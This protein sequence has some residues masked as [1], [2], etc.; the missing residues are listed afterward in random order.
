MSGKT[1]KIRVA[2]SATEARSRQM[3]CKKPPASF[4]VLINAL[5]CLVLCLPAAGCVGSSQQSASEEFTQ[6]PGRYSAASLDAAHP[7]VGLPLPFVAVEEGVAS[8]VRPNDD[9]AEQLLWLA[10]QTGRFNLV[11]HERLTELLSQQ[12]HGDV[13]REASLVQP[14]GIRGIDYL[15]LC[16]VTGLRIHGQEQPTT[17]SVANVERLL[18]ISKAAPKVTAG[19]L[20]D[21]RLVDPA[22]GTI[23]AEQETRFN[24]SASPDAMGLH[25]DSP[26]DAF[27]ELH[28]SDQQFSQVLRIILDDSMR[29]MLPAVD[30]RLT[31]AP[32]TQTATHTRAPTAAPITAATRPATPSAQPAGLKLHCPDCGYEVSADDEFCPNCGKR[33]LQNGAR[34]EGKLK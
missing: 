34:I 17:V 22:T 33:L 16:R 6:S 15:L 27:G 14:V 8:G 25:F 10:S 18:H 2:A 11:E 5:L 19:A 12:G 1:I 21:L 4:C 24:R 9:A 30:S 20:V 26:A 23:A 13:V 29:R 3:S 31:N 7:R 28:L 32:P